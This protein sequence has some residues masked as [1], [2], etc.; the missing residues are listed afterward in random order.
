M[1]KL[2]FFL[3]LVIMLAGASAFY[4]LWPNT[5]VISPIRPGE[6][7]LVIEGDKIEGMGTPVVEKGSVLLPFPVVKEYI[8]PKIYWD[9]D[10]NKVIITTED[11]VIRMKT[12]NLTAMVNA[13][14][15][16]LN[17]PV[18]LIDDIPYVP[19]DLLED[20]FDVDVKWVEATE[21]V[22]IDYTGFAQRVGEVT[23]PKAKVRREPSIKSPIY[24]DDL[25]PGQIVRVFEEDEKWYKVRTE[26]GIIGYM[27][28]RFLSTSLTEVKGV[29]YDEPQP[30]TW[31]PDKGKINMVWEYVHKETP[32]ISS[33]GKIKGVD[34][35]TP[36]WFH[37]VDGSGTVANKADKKYVDDAHREGY[38]VW[39]LVTNN[40]DPEITHEVLN[41]TETREKVIQQLLVYANLYELDGI[42]IDFENVYVKDR[43]MLTQFVRELAPLF[44]E[45]GL[46]VS[47]DVTVK[48]SSENWSLCYD[49]KALGEV[50]DYMAVMAYDQHWEAS[51]VA[52][53]VAEITWVENG[54]KAILEEVPSHKILLGLPFYAREWKEEIVDGRKRVTSRAL[55][56][57]GVQKIISDKKLDKVWDEKSG[58]YYVEY[59]EGR[60]VYKIW[61]ED[62]RSIDLRSSLV[63][64]YDLAG[65]ACWRRGFETEDIWEVLNDNLKEKQNYAQ[66]LEDNGFKE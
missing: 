50:V 27:E 20:L 6:T 21:T 13:R 64:K 49:R 17:I 7:S 43:D 3:V 51:P 24:V 2:R 65:V 36:T 62:A 12:D 47:I 41:S 5:S 59:S 8:D 42:N 34:V 45:Q 35:L 10:E 39:G 26:E 48:S 37:I 61:V 16:E 9:R 56:M 30:L 28:K 33:F 52:G 22:I 14:P 4:F 63:H 55:Y 53:S 66:W 31:K 57:E 1:N 11:K 29:S 38:K 54:I 40:F 25:Q 32:D 23:N 15:V 19:A 18:R 60:A 46:V 44:K 58:Q